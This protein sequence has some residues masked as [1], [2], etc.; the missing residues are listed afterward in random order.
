MTQT[1]WDSCLKCRHVCAP[2][3]LPIGTTEMQK[4]HTTRSKWQRWQSKRGNRIAKKW[5]KI[6]RK[7][8]VANKSRSVKSEFLILVRRNH[9]LW[10][11]FV[12]RFASFYLLN[13]FIFFS[14]AFS[15]WCFAIICWGV[16]CFSRSIHCFVDN[17][18]A[19]KYATC[20]SKWCVMVLHSIPC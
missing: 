13:Y 1:K 4:I 5:P 2:S 14:L 10:V 3:I 18:C 15:L 17:V 9:G 19:I 16:H 6:F 20:P 11:I 12:L 8:W 7:K